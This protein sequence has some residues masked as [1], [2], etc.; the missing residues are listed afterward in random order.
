MQHTMHASARTARG[1]ATTIAVREHHLTADE[2]VSEGGHDVGPT[3]VE[4][5]LSGLAACTTITARMYADRK[6]Y[7][8]EGITAHA[9][10]EQGAGS[11][12]P[13]IRLEID[14]RGPLTAEQRARVVEIAGRCPVHRMIERATPV[15]T[16]DV[17][18]SS[19]A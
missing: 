16:V 17:S 10:L 2:P 15:E 18:D 8:V 4:L 6:G 1:F 7:E 11:T 14:V 3:P 5:M 9:S 19:P 13:S 12:G